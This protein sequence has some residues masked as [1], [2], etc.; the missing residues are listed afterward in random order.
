M[1]V[2]ISLMIL[3][4]KHILEGEPK[5]VVMLDSKFLYILK[6]HKKRFGINLSKIGLLAGPDR[7]VKNMKRPNFNKNAQKRQI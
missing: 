5:F 4:A 3:N 1:G 7:G 6:K 2:N